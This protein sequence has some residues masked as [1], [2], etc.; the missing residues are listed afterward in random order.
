MRNVLWSIS[1]TLFALLISGAILNAHPGHDHPPDLRVWKD[2]EGLFEIEA[3]FVQASDGRVQLC[4]HDGTLVWVPLDRLSRPDQAWVQMRVDE[5]RR[6]NQQSPAVAST[7]S[8]S[9]LPSNAEADNRQPASSLLAPSLAGAG[10]LVAVA[11]GALLLKRRRIVVLPVLILLGSLA[12]LGLAV[13]E[14]AGQKEPPVI[15]KHF[16]P[17]KD[18]LKLR[19]DDNF[20]YVESNG[21]PDHP[22]M[23]GDQGLAAASAAASTIH[24]QKRLADPAQ[25]A[26]RGQANLGQDRLVSRGNRPGG[27]RRADFQRPQ[28]P[29]RRCVLVRRIGRV[30]RP[31]RPGATTTTTTSPRCIWRRSSARGIRSLTPSTAI[32][33]MATPTPTAKNPTTSTSSTAGWKRTATATTPPRSTRTSTA[34]CAASYRFKAIKSIRNREPRPV[35]PAGVPLRGA[36]ITGVHA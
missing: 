29:R 9:T 20:L 8:I 5:I 24:R 32:R 3:S 23:V 21:V 12:S 6:L 19:S 7:D 30:R 31:L 18:K 2:A 17:F 11:L 16:E 36:T 22:M 13:E 25:A 33:S 10:I 4:K 26:A 27:Q 34:A 35:R 15:Q 1:A 14:P 28:Q